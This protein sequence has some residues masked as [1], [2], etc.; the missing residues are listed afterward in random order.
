MGTNAPPIPA[1][2][3]RERGRHRRVILASRP[4]HSTSAFAG[5]DRLL[6]ITL[7]LIWVV[8]AVAGLAYGMGYYLTPIQER[9]FAARHD[10]LKPSGLVGEGY[11]VIGTLCMVLGVT[12][13]TA[14]KRVRALAR[15]G[16]LKS[17][18]QVHIFLCTIGPFL[19]LLHT[20][21]KIGGV[22]SI[23]FWSMTLVVF[24]GFFGRFIYAH[25]PKTIHG[26]FLTKRAIQEKKAE[27]IQIIR[28]ECHLTAERTR[29]FLL[30]APVREPRGFLH[31]VVLAVK[32]DHSKRSRKRHL[33]R[34]LSAS[35]IP[36]QVRERTITLVL[37]QISLQQQI[38]LLQPFQ[39]LFRYWH[40]LHL[41]LST[42]MVLILLIHIAIAIAFGY[43][44]VF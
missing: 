5:A 22:V 15:V 27:L 26:Q 36:R 28:T 4:R 44:W 2:A 40:I 10:L 17:W 3:D 6:L 20:G 42:V 24:S 35:S 7:I 16:R 39:R 38:V 31:A 14:R 23:A 13:Y 21:F 11:G 30:V 34:L 37:E 32:Y 19:V 18:L 1:L 12:M 29:Q 41:P 43:T 8:V 25:I 9:A 33:Q